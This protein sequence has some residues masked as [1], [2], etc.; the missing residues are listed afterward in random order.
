M[1][2]SFALCSALCLTILATDAN[3]AYANS[4]LPN[5]PTYVYINDAYAEWYKTRF[6]VDLDR[7]TVLP[8]LHALSRHDRRVVSSLHPNVGSWVRIAAKCIDSS[9]PIKIGWEA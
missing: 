1:R 5:V 4:P 9:Q 6:D 3:N 8:V 7:A 2:L